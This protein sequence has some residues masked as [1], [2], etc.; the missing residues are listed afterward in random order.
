M[1]GIGF[2]SAAGWR[3]T[4]SAEAPAVVS[5]KLP[6]LTRAIEAARSGGANLIIIDTPPQSEG[7]A[8]AAARAANFVLIPVR[9]SSFD[10]RAIGMTADLVRA[11]GKSAAALLNAAPPQASS[12]IAEARAAIA[13]HGIEAAPP[14]LSLRAAFVHA[15]TAGLGV[16]EYEPDGR[17]AAEIAELWEWIAR[18]LG[19]SKRK[20]K[21]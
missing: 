4:R 1:S 7:S 15:A 3:D 19:I 16:I 8:V 11:A 18:Q 2:E 13:M 6:R 17:A 5:I 14:T 21:R 20:G 10:L 9:P 12:M